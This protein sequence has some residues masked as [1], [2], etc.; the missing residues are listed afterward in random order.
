M[1]QCGQYLILNHAEYRFIA[2]SI[3]NYRLIASFACFQL[4]TVSQHDHHARDLNC[5]EIVLLDQLLRQ[6]NCGLH[7]YL[8]KLQY[9]ADS[10]TRPFTTG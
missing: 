9:Q 7:H 1:L 8:E 2:H 3:C 6:Q 10:P 5:I 4:T